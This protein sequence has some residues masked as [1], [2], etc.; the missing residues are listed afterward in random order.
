MNNEKNI[1]TYYQLM[2]NALIILQEWSGF[3]EEKDCTV[4]SSVH[5]WLS[6]PQ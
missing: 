3:L 6:A 4:L 2:Q 5:T 1:I